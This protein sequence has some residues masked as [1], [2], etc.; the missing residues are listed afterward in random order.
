M[1]GI[2]LAALALEVVA[3]AGCVQCGNPDNLMQQQFDPCPSPSSYCRAL[4]WL[5]LDRLSKQDL[6]LILI[7]S[8]INKETPNPWRD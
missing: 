4:C 1:L 5:L 6:Y 2:M 8:T 3:Y 7:T